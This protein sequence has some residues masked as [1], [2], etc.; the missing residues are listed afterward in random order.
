M[1]DQEIRDTVR[2]ALKGLGRRGRPQ[3]SSGTR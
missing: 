1:N 3:T 2:Q